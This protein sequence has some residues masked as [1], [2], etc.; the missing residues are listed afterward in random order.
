MLIFPSSFASSSS[1][2]SFSFSSC[3]TGVEPLKTAKQSLK[4]SYPDL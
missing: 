1:S 2:S 3:F 4:Y